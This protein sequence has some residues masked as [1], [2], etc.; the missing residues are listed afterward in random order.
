MT[1]KTLPVSS[2]ET[3][4]IFPRW[5]SATHCAMESPSP[6]P[7]VLVNSIDNFA[8]QI[9]NHFFSPPVCFFPPEDAKVF[10]FGA[11]LFSKQYSSICF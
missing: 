2:E 7:L 9:S 4:S 3:S 5:T 1:A 11:V 6:A 8:K 10:H